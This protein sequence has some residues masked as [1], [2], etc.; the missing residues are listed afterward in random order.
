METS[1]LSSAQVLERRARDGWNDLPTAR[2]RG[3]ATAVLAA[4]REPMTLLLLVCGAVY[5]AIGDREE[6]LMLVG[7]VVFIMGLTLVQERK[8]ERAIEALRDL[9]SPRALVI[10]DGARVRVAG[11]E[12]VTDDLVVLAEGDRVP[13]DAV[14]LEASH[15]SADE[16]LLTGESVPVRKSAWNGAQ[17]FARPGGED[18]PFVFAGTLVASGA[19]LARVHTTASRTEIGRIGLA[20]QAKSV[21]DTPL[22]SE[23][24]RLVKKLAWLAAG[25]SILATVAYALVTRDVLRGVL[26]GLTLA[27][28]ILPNEFPVVVT[29]FLALGAWR[30]SQRSVLTRRMPAVESLGAVTVLCVDKTGTLT[31]NR[32][33]VARVAAGGASVAIYDPSAPL[34]GPARRTVEYAVRASRADPFDP[35]ERAITALR[36]AAGVHDAGWALVREYPLTSARLAVVHVWRAPGRAELVVSAKGAPETI[37]DLCGA[38]RAGV[39][40]EVRAL[41]RDGLRVLGV[42]SGSFADGPLPDDPAELGLRFVGL[43][44]LADPL[45]PAVRRAV[46]ECRNAG[47]RVVMITGDYP[48]TALSIARAAGIDAAR[49]VTGAELVAMTEEELRAAVRETSVFARVLPEH[50]LALVEAFSAN[51]EVVGMTGDG[52][53]D[54]PALRAAHVGVAMGGRGTD[55]AREAA[56]VVLLEDDFASLVMG[57]RGGRRIIDNLRK[58]LAYILAVHLPIVGLTLVPIALGGPLVLLP[59]H[60]AFLHLVIDPACSI[61]FEA[62]PEEVDVMKRPPRDPREPLFGRRVLGLSVL[63]GL[64]V[65]AVV[66]AVYVTALVLRQP[67]NEVRAL[68][69]A[70][71]L[72][73]NV[74]LIFTNRSWSR[75]VLASSLRDGALWTVTAGAVA[76]LGLVIYVPPLAELFRFAPLGAVDVVLCFGAGAA[77]IAWFEIVKLR[78]TLGHHPGPTGATEPA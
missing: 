78:R 13:A 30:L 26:A 1:G 5:A 62:Q 10:R 44:G 38:A 65:L 39:D 54:A 3:L 12:L 72:V 17:P 20:I 8:T 7:F 47:I 37:A 53:N 58:A 22:Q 61:V 28:A 9:A 75:V 4:V 36:A 77:S 59:I 27:M 35:M 60:V 15:V 69:F 41:A 49:V 64:S 73:S 24:R 19:G 48:E 18:L 33:A 11:R 42:A 23:T 57:V 16:S 68:S 43:I 71:F 56:S 55:V 76:F 29:M 45:R 6:A 70:T 32:M 14:L 21:P 46:A 66:L 51:G 40:R 67:E 74:A 50:K 25:L 63:Q 34:A 2:R 31:M 52:V